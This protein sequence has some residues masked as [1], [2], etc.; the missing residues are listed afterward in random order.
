M[1]PRLKTATCARCKRRKIRCN[2][3]SPCI[4]CDKMQTLCEYNEGKTTG[5]SAV[6]ELKR[7]AACL[8][9]RRKKKRC[10]GK[11]PCN[12]CLLSRS[13]TQCEYGESETQDSPAASTSASSSPDANGLSSASS[14][15]SPP[16]PTTP[17]DIM[18]PI[19]QMEIQ[20]PSPFALPE[21]VVWSDLEQ[22]RDLFITTTEENGFVTPDK[23]PLYPALP[24][25]SMYDISV[26]HGPPLPD[27]EPGDELGAIRQLFIAHHTQ[28]G[29]SVSDRLLSAI[30]TGDSN[31]EHL[32]PVLF[33]ACQL[34]GFMLARHRP[35]AKHGSDNWVALPGQSE[36]ETEQ[37]RLAL[38]ALHDTTRSPC[39]FAYLQTSALLSTYFFNKGDIGRA[40][41]MVAHADKL[42]REHRL[43]SYTYSCGPAEPN[44]KQGFRVTPVSPVSDATAA[45][46]QIVY[47]D[48]SYAIMLNL[49]TLL[50][51]SLVE[52]FRTIATSPNP[53]AEV[54]FIRAK[55]AFLLWEARQL[56]L[57]W[58]DLSL[59]DACKEAWQTRYWHLMDEL[60]AHKSFITVTLT[61]AAFC[62]S[63][64]VLG[65]A[66]KVSVILTLTGLATLLSVF[67]RDNKE[68]IHKKHNA[69]SEVIHISSMFEE[70]D[71]IYLDPILSA[72]WHAVMGTVQRCLVSEERDPTTCPKGAD[73]YNASRMANLL[74]DQNSTLK[75]VLPFA[76][77]I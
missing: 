6:P 4:T 7:G 16:H 48:L 33:H 26:S 41:D 46:S 77:E 30:A 44:A 42:I 11:F 74:R 63:L 32:H 72:C 28:L 59:S 17:E 8:Q 22:A 65:L 58:N 55:S 23:P 49:P 61:R 68:L 64:H 75:R 45:I 14:S 20:D 34:L 12:T 47:L 24:K 3:Q 57:E 37:I 25:D 56:V 9:C 18:I 73:M 70:G 76:L 5:R 67:E 13:K 62:P 66:L 40:R 35:M 50:H 43:D 19:Q 38:S 53:D 69:I 2:G 60:D 54:N 1:E 27:P 52:R 31:E 10:D 39:P 29:L 51:P 36:R 71:Y 15:D 21:Y